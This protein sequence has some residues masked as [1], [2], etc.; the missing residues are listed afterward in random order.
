MSWQA[1]PPGTISVV[2]LSDLKPLQ[3]LEGI[4]GCLTSMFCPVFGFR[5]V[6][7][8]LIVGVN[9]YVCGTPTRDPDIH[10]FSVCKGRNE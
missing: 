4:D 10:R 3:L 9:G 2:F 7:S 6:Y 1:D 8:R 5:L